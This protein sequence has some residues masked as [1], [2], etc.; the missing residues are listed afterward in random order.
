MIAAVTG[1]EEEGAVVALE[2]SG[3]PSPELDL[4]LRFERTDLDVKEFDA[5]EPKVF[6]PSL[7]SLPLLPS[8]DNFDVSFESALSA[9][10]DA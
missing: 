3:A 9:V 6:L 10:L 4:L 2:F 5:A 1:A 8:E 7:P